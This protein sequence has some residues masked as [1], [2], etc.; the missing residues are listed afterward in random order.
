MSGRE[1]VVT[2]IGL[3]TSLGEG[4]AAN[5]DALMAGAAPVIDLATTPPFAIHPPPALDLDRQIP[6][7]G[8]Q[9]QMEPWQRLGV[10]AA[11]L[12]LAEAGL[13]GNPDLLARTHM[14][15]AA[16]GGERDE[17][18]DEALMRELPGAASPGKLVNERLV[19]DLR[20]T[21]FLA[22]L[23]NLL[24]GNVSIVHG[25]SGSSRTFMGE[26]SAGASALGTLRARIAAGQGDIGLVG[27]AYSAARRDMQ[28]VFSF[29]RALIEGEPGPVWARA[30]R[31]G[32]MALGT[33]GAF[34][35]LEAREHAAARGARALAALGPVAAGWTRRAPGEARAEAMRA[36]AKVGGGEG[37]LPVLSGATGAEPITGEERGFLDDLSAERPLAVRATGTKLGHPIEC[38]MI[39]NV[40]LAA[41]SLDAGRFY[42]P[43]DDTGMEAEFEGRPREV[44]VTSFGAW[45][46][47][48]LALVTTPEGA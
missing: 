46:G 40:A 6:K 16:G 31:G 43:F 17:G 27:G 42:P 12:A 11:G 26:E 38:S 34:L 7:K 25:V 15:V 48:A 4:G 3:V 45:R 28:L 24:A 30:P 37:P 14:V 13:A 36:W 2:G 22:Q 44:L 39:C 1:V 20:P 41:L 29:G 10:Y 19:N 8:D 18:V 33:V 32:G 21:L 35:V 5:R 9:R 47:E 23:S